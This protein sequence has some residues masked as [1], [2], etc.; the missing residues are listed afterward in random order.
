LGGIGTVGGLSREN[1]GARPWAVAGVAA[2]LT[3]EG[4]ALTLTAPPVRGV[5]RRCL[6]HLPG[7][8]PVFLTEA[9]IALLVLAASLRQPS[10]RAVLTTGTSLAVIGVVVAEVIAGLVRRFLAL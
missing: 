7:I 1:A 3:G 2:I 8:T 5:G 4:F 6:R 10:P 9:V